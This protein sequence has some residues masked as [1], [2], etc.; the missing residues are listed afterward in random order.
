M[1]WYSDTVDSRFLLAEE[2]KE[3]QLKHGN[4]IRG[5]KFD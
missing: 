4:L 5:M 3:A 2:D 1:V